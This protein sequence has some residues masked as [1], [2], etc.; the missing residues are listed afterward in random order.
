[1][2]KEKELKQDGQDRQDEE[3]KKLKTG[4]FLHPV[5]PAHPV[6]TLCSR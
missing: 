3:G 1:M 2:K 6:V 5:Y 4:F